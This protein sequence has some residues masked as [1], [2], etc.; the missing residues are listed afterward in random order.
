MH[1]R[2]PGPGHPV[3]ESSA[4]NHKMAAHAARELAAVQ[5][6]TIQARHLLAQVQRAVQAA[7]AKLEGPAIIEERECTVVAG[8][9]ATVRLD[10]WGS[11][12]L[13]LPAPAETTPPAKE[14]AHAAPA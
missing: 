13:D 7:G 8:P 12:F 9:S 5:Q 14:T 3:R 6:Q 4:H 1:H 10:P 11:L 2:P